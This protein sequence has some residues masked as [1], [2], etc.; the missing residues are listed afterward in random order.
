MRF[1]YFSILFLTALLPSVAQ[2]ATNAG[3]GLPKEP[4]E[5]FAAAAPFYD[6]SAAELKPW[7]LKATY[8]LYDE[9]GQ[10]ADKGNY[11]YWWAAPAV[12]RSTWT[13]TSATHTDWHLADGR[14]SHQSSGDPLEFFEYK[15]KGELLSPL[16]S[17]ADLDPEK[18]RMERE[19]VSLGGVKLPC[20]MVAPLMPQYGQLQNIPLGLFPTYCFDP[21]L[22]VL[23]ISYSFGT[24]ATEYNHVVK[25]QNRYLAREI[26]M[27]EGTRKLLSATV[28]SINYI[29]ASDPALT[30]TVTAHMD[31]IDSAQQ[32]SPAVMSIML[33]KK[34]KPIY[35]QDAKDA[36]VS[37][38]VKLQA[39]IGMDGG[40]HELR[41]VSAPWPSLVASALWA[42]SHWQYKPYLLNGEPVDVAT[43]IDVIYSLDY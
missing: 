40:V 22:P 4:R 21:N 25:L 27:Y 43:T 11:E 9:K 30:P 38:T 19:L 7:H 42:V 31:K 5:V 33:I 12:Y 32:I 6:F 14:F 2:T 8:Q 3:L 15:L 18:F 16:P 23:R 26:V 20:L 41:V 35:P 36:R 34:Q 1:V 17:A 28:D 13:R 10:A 29:N 37:G 24:L 39:I